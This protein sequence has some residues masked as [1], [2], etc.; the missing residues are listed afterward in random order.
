[1]N[2]LL[3]VHILYAISFRAQQIKVSVFIF[4]RYFVF[5]VRWLNLFTFSIQGN[6]GLARFIEN[7]QATFYQVSINKKS[8]NCPS[9]VS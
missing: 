1:M 5:V 6:Q 7:G 9:R 3:P 4:L 8:N 2:R